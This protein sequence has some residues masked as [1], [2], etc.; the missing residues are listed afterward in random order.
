MSDLAKPKTASRT[1]FEIARNWYSADDIERCI[2]RQRFPAACYGIAKVPEDIY[3]REFAEWL[4]DQ[5]RLAMAK[6]IQLG[7][8]GSVD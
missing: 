1:P 7:R 2:H 4:T 5:Y 3:S 8:E 6:G